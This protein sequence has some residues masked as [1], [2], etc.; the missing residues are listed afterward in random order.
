MDEDLLDTEL[1]TSQ[2]NILLLVRSQ[3]NVNVC[4]SACAAGNHHL[5]IVHIAGSESGRLGHPV[6]AELEKDHI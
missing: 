5:G 2:C 4:I 1:V 3:L 6:V